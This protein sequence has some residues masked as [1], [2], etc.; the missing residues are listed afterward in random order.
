MSVKLLPGFLNVKAKQSRMNIVDPLRT[1][2][3]TVPPQ[4]VPG[5]A[6][7]NTK[8]TSENMSKAS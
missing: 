1:E 2:K 6:T 5:E 3:R 8:S 4:L 7:E